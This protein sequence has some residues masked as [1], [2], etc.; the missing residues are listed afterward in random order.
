MIS[1]RLTT[2][3][4]FMP[5]VK[6]LRAFSLA[7]VLESVS[8]DHFF[9]LL[10]GDAAVVVGVDQ[11][12]DLIELIAPRK[13]SQMTPPTHQI[14]PAA[15]GLQPIHTPRTLRARRRQREECL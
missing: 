11:L 15:V 8:L 12:D 4:R 9:E 10:L 1:V 14:Q 3:N 2:P 6:T 5:A 13:C 7:S